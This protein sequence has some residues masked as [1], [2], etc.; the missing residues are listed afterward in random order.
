MQPEFEHYAS[1]AEQIKEKNKKRKTLLAEKKFTPV[2][3]IPKHRELSRCIA[4]MTEKLEELRSKKA[5]LLAALQ[6]TEDTGVDTIR[7]DIATMKAGMKRL[8][9]QE[10]KYTIEFDNVLKA[11]AELKEQ[12]TDLDL[13]QLMKERLALCLEKERSTVTRVQSAYD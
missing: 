6:Y 5:R 12:T 8:E 10:Q 2:L 11:Y 7:N 3:Q 9:Q 4:E 13:N 1:I